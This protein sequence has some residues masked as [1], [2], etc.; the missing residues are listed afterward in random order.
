M[1]HL[2][3][4]MKLRNLVPKLSSAVI[5]LPGVLKLDLMPFDVTEDDQVPVLQKKYLMI[6]F[7]LLLLLLKLL[8]LLLLQLLI[9]LLLIIGRKY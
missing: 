4:L 2:S 3:Q 1:R 9:L 6:Y 7:V 8:L 5:L